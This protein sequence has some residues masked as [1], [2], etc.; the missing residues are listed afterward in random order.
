[1]LGLAEALF[2]RFL[3]PRQPGAVLVFGQLAHAAHAPVAQVVDVIHFALAVAQVHQDFHHI[4]NV[5]VR[6][7]HSPGAAAAP[8]A[9]VEL[10]APH[11]R[12]VVGVGVVK[13]AV[14]QRLHR[15]F[16]GRLAGAHHAVDG[17]AG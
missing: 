17:H 6:Q 12:E 2:H 1:M 3:D 13:Q 15:V 8:D 10:H 7:H 16:G 4:Q 14:K 9:G 11:A 5:F